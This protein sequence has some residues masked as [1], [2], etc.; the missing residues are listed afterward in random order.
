MSESNPYTFCTVVVLCRR[1]MEAERSQADDAMLSLQFNIVKLANGNF[2]GVFRWQVAIIEIDRKEKQLKNSFSNDNGFCSKVFIKID[3][4]WTNIKVVYIMR[5]MVFKASNCWIFT[6]Q[7]MTSLIAWRLPFSVRI[8]SFIGYKITSNLCWCMNSVQS[9][10]P[11]QCVFPLICYF[12][13]EWNPTNLI[14]TSTCTCY[15]LPELLSVSMRRM[16]YCWMSYY[17]MLGFVQPSGM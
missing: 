14:I 10:H 3:Q 9:P 15:Q 4:Y 17:K 8:C 5:V 12:W 7:D 11:W 16:L 6:S 2:H 13:P 1:S